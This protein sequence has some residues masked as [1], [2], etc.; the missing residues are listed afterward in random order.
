MSWIQDIVNPKKR[1]W[2]EFYR[3]RFQHDKIVRSTHG[4]NCTGSCSW[5]VAVKDGIVVWET[6][7]LDY[8]LLDDKLPPYEP[9]GCQRGISFSWYIYSPIRIKYPLIRGALLDAYREKKA[10]NGGDAMKAWEAL[11]ADKA[12][13]KAYQE[14]RG[15]GGF[16]IASWEEANEIMAVANIYTA[17]KYGPDRVVGFSPIPA[18]SMI[19][20]SSGARFLQLFGGVN[21][22]FYDW[23]CDLPP[24]FPEVWGE[25]TDC[26]ESADWYNAKMIVD[27]GANLN[28]T[29]TP[30]AHFFAEARHNGTKTIVCAPDFSMVSKFADQWV[31]LHAGS[32]G[33]FWLAIT[34]VLLKEFY[35]DR[36]VPYFIDYIKKYTDMPFLIKIDEES[37]EYKSGRLLRA[38]ELKE[39][40]DIE[41]GDWKFIQI[42]EDSKS[43]VVPKGTVGHRWSKEKSGEWNTKL[44]NSIDNRPYNPKLSL[45]DDSDDVLNVTFEEFGL[46]VKAKR[47]VP[48]KY[49][50]T[51]DGKKVAVATIFDV[52]MAH[53]GVPRGL[54][55]DYPED[56][57]DKKSAYTPAW[58]E[59]FTGID[60]KTI[61]QI[62]REWG[63]NG[64][65]TQGKNMVIV[66]AGVN[67]WYH[68]NLM[69]RSAIMALMFTGSIGRNGGGMNHY[70][71]QEKLA[72]VDSWGNITFAKDWN[73]TARLQQAP[74]WHYLNTDQY[75]YDGLH[76]KYNAVPDNDMT[77][78]HMA[79]EIYKS[80]RMGHMPYYPQFNKNPLEL[81][82]ES[83]AKSDEEIKEYVLKSLKDKSLEYAVGDVD[84]EE[85]FPRIW[86]I[87]RGNSI[88]GSMKG[89]EYALKHYLG[90]H[91]NT[92]ATDQEP[93]QEIK[94]H[95]EAPTG[96][97]DLVVDLN[98]RMDSSAL[99]SDI[100]LPTASWYEKADINTTDMHSFIHPL[101]EAV[102]PV[103]EAKTDWD[104][105][106]G[107]AKATSEV[108]K[109]HMPEPVKDVV[110]L[111]LGHDTAD[112]IA[113]SSIKDWYKG[114]CEAI[115]GKTMHKIAVEE[116]DYTKIYDKFVTLG[117]NFREKGGGAHGSSYACDDI[118]DEMVN[119]NHFHTIEYEGEKYPSLKE[120]VDAINAVLN[121]SSVTN[122]KLAVRAYKNAEKKT[123]LDDLS[124]IIKHKE[125]VKM[126]YKD[127]QKAPHRYH[128][129]PVWAGLMNNDRAYAPYTYNV[130]KSVPW[131]TLTGRQ[132][133]YL[134]HEMYIAYGEHLPTYKPSPK[135]E[136]YGDLRE[137]V[138]NGE[139]KVLSCLTPHGKWHIHST[140]M[141]NIRMLTL[142]RGIEPIWINEEDAEEMDIKDNDWVEVI[143]DN[144]VYSTRAVVSSRI[145]K[146]VTILYHTIER[147]IGLP[148]SQE[149]KKRSGGNNAVTRVRLKPNLLAGGYGQFTYYFNYWGPVAVNRDTHVIIKKMTEV[150]F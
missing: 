56:Y 64:E 4:V 72:P 125:G 82:K 12:K 112:E 92:I 27:M 31:P 118:Y 120:D 19:S 111:P 113:Q 101:S 106:K 81:A 6:Q 84:A 149:R 35:V 95:E 145:P 54:S 90:T 38:N 53:Y 116:R 28:M 50:T 66:G 134:D 57:N 80:V 139:A 44:E 9:R 70:V 60:S 39:F 73:S 52:M 114:E 110:T 23:Y 5:Q 61:I 142:S 7:Q 102:P 104:I 107:I 49:V 74:I 140:Y 69:Y 109:V 94:W 150:V 141:D 132:H 67:H 75:R 37:G 34:H 128:S 18:M 137:T 20:Y 148:I 79:D 2:E 131:R 47:G 16:R 58:Q 10:Q 22:S 103:W 83:G 105:F 42:D 48:V 130:E 40:K 25:Q 121:L 13:R 147:T 55:G 146:G 136:V 144:G 133:S 88:S 68:C 127:L 143:N 100:V 8:P 59:I 1:K 97:M 33:A 41:N 115:P 96:K 29:R 62:A 99:Y 89:Q 26:A 15:K 86:Y 51:T 87:W 117:R 91:N 71:G 21:L 63:H 46:D 24:A 135:P 76:S 14:A 98:F 124:S 85:N 126:Q 17:K 78:G 93:T 3:N 129:S 43:F 122:G 123:G 45:I 138:K 11:Q 77:K 36:E 119:S 32:D 65:V 108:A 30:D